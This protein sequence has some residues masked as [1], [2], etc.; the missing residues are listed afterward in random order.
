[1][2][3]L[4]LSQPRA[5]LVALRAKQIDT[6]GWRTAYRGP[7]AIQAAKEIPA[8]AVAFYE[9][10]ER[11]RALLEPLGVRSSTDLAEL[12]RQ[13]IVATCELVACVSTNPQL[14]TGEYVAPGRETLEYEA[15]YYTPGRYMFF[16]ANIQALAVPIPCKGAHRLW[17]VPEEVRHQLA[18]AA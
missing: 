16:L 14:W 2:M 17:P 11:A 4:S 5:T 7:L 10:S 6:R 8:E 13:V 1:M 15:G 12:P 9:R 3:G 18:R